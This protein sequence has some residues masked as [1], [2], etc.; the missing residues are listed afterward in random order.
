MTVFFLRKVHDSKQTKT[1]LQKYNSFLWPT[2]HILVFLIALFL[3]VFTHAS[4]GFLFFVFIPIAVIKIMQIKSIESCKNK[5]CYKVCFIS[6]I[7]SSSVLKKI[8]IIFL[9]LSFV[10]HHFHMHTAAF[11]FFFLARIWNTAHENNSIF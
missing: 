2:Y 7:S 6:Y 10:T 5:I 11:F 9:S 8:C 3:E 4:N 1:F